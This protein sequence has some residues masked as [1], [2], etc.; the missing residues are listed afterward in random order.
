MRVQPAVVRVAVDPD[1]EEI[2][3]ST[4]NFK[5][6]PK[7]FK[8]KPK[9][10][11]RFFKPKE[12]LQ[13]GIEELNPD[14]DYA[15][16]RYFPDDGGFRVITDSGSG[17]QRSWARALKRKDPTRFKAAFWKLPSNSCDLYH[18]PTHGWQEVILKPHRHLYFAVQK[19]NPKHYEKARSRN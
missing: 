19:V 11:Q 2:P 4:G 6:T 8:L 10:R 14:T 18:E 7:V 17:L 16:F 13:I 12:R 5:V 1:L 9:P 3:V 15:F